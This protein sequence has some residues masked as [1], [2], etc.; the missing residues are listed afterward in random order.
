MDGTEP[1]AGSRVAGAAL[2]VIAAVVVYGWARWCFG[3]TSAPSTTVAVGVGA[4]LVVGAGAGYL[5]LVGGNAGVFGAILLALGLLTAVALAD[6][7]AVRGEVADCV[8]SEV[9][10]K[11]EGSSGEGGPTPR[12][13][14]RHVVSCPGGYPSELK[15]DRQLAPKGGRI[16]VAYDPGRRVSPEPEGARPPWAPL[17]LALGLLGGAT[18]LAAH[19]PARQEGP[20]G[21]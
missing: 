19:R 11:T 21:R 18:A 13:V 10:E 3:G 17:L 4:I 16:R 7:T 6:R 2:V 8:V 1:G 12:T 5:R 20:P 14:Y 15:D 9:H